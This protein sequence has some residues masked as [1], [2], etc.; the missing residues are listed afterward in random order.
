MEQLTCQRGPSAF[1]RT[2]DRCPQWVWKD[3]RCVDRE[4]EP[5]FLR[6]Y[7]KTN[8]KDFLWC[9]QIH[10]AAKCTMKHTQ[11][12]TVPS[13]P[14]PLSVPLS[15]TLSG[16]RDKYHPNL[17]SALFQHL[18]FKLRAGGPTHTL[19]CTHNQIRLWHGPGAFSLSLKDQR[20]II[21]YCLLISAVSG[22][23]P[24]PPFHGRHSVPF[25]KTEWKITGLL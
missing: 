1:W 14:S 8:A 21:R 5:G 9:C 12:H 2:D 22:Q 24:P 16:S 6:V 10:G 17:F 3:W 19:L 20:D 25:D 23:S 15:P 4:W 7:H 11:T 13:P 18:H